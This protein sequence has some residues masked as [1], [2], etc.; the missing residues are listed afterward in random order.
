MEN[1]IKGGENN[2]KITIIVVLLILIFIGIFAGI[3]KITGFNLLGIDFGFNNDKNN[4]QPV[5]EPVVI[6]PPQIKDLEIKEFYPEMEI[7]PKNSSNATV[8][9]IIY[10]GLKIPY[11]IT[12]EFFYEDKY[13]GKWFNVSTEIYDVNKEENNYYSYQPIFDNVGDWK[14]QLII[15]YSFMGVPFKKSKTVSFKVIDREP[16]PLTVTFNGDGS[17]TRKY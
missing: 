15:D 5:N 9:F 12:V 11:N 6:Q 8:K 14:V 7:F 17:V 10:N 16:T 4:N 3:L 1:Q 13:I 2:S